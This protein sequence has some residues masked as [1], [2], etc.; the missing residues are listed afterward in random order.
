MIRRW[1]FLIG[2][3][4]AALLLVAACGRGAS[5]SSSVP[6]DND[7]SPRA[8]DD[9][10]NDDNDDNDDDNDA[11]LN[12]IEREELGAKWDCEYPDWCVSGYEDFLTLAAAHAHPLSVGDLYNQIGEIEN[13]DVTPFTETLPEDEL[14]ATILNDLNIGFLVEGLDARPL[15]VTTTRIEVKDGVVGRH[16]LFTDPWVGTFEGILLTPPGD[17]PFPGIVAV[18]GHRSFAR[19]YML[20]YHGNEWPSHGYAI[21]MITL[22]VMGIGWV[23]HDIAVRLLENGFTLMGLHS[24]E[25]LL[26]LKYLRWLPNI[27][28]EHIGM[29]G[30]SGGSSTSNLTI[31]YAPAVAAYVS[32]L[33]KVYSEWGTLFE[34]FHCE[35]IPQIYPYNLLINDFSTAPM[36]VKTVPYAYANGMQ[37]IFDFFDRQL[38]P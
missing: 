20:H 25:S 21:L 2:V 27:E 36:P 32:D 4:C 11:A 13:G 31:R 12:V 38:K 14:R 15:T 22:R 5:S 28:H 33:Q 9:D 17:G 18:H 26:G 1:S 16:L 30:H 37:E 19:N 7:A 35:T 23:E 10:D 24:Y 6:A 29:I 8:D 34:P 3:A